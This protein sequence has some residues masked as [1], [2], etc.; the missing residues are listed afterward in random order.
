MK[1]EIPSWFTLDQNDLQDH[2]S[3][4][5]HQSIC[6]F[7]T[8]VIARSQRVAVTWIDCTVE[9]GLGADPALRNPR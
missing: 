5:P 3:A 4:Q 8:A 1:F 9:I 7:T 2:W 6:D